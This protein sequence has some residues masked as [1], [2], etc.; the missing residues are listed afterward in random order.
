MGRRYQVLL[1]RV[2]FKHALED[3]M[4]RGIGSIYKAINGWAK[5]GMHGK[6]TISFLHVTKETSTEL[7]T[8]LRAPF[9]K[10]GSIENYWCYVAPE[11]AV[12]NKGGDPFVHWLTA[13]WDKARQWNASEDVGKSKFFRNFPKRSV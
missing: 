11:V 7:H 1:L 12:A 10:V 13:A 2:D 8:R 9:E 5:P 6:A 3:I 4:E